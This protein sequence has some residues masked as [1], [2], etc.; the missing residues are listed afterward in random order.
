MRHAWYWIVRLL[1]KPMLSSRVPVGMQ[2][3]WGRLCGAL[4][5]GPRGSRYRS[6]RLGTVAVLS[7]YPRK[8]RSGHGV[9]F[10]HGGAYVMGGFGSHRK[11]ATAVGDAAGAKVWLPDYRLAPESPHPAALNDALAVYTGLLEQGQ[12]PDRLSIVGDS[13]GAGLALTLAVAIREAGLPSPASLVLLSPWV[14][15]SLSGETIASH[16]RRDPMI[17]ADWLQWAGKLYRGHADRADP[18]CSPL[19]ADL[20]GLPPILIQVGS[21]EI[22]LSD[23]QRL[24]QRCEEAGVACDLREYAGLWHVFQLH[25][26]W[27]PEADSA[28]TEI[29]GF[30]KNHEK[31][32]QASSCGECYSGRHR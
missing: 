15:L 25:F 24:H 27:L 12:N 19:F 32:P 13:A 21:E 3:I 8:Y 5:R 20:R 4:L 18:A 22:L 26:G 17:S 10:L 30:I 16:R 31:T 9:L 28:I 7:I 11:L 6:G 23:A 1:I 2:R 14:D 29:G